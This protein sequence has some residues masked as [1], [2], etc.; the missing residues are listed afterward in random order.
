MRPTEPEQ[1]EISDQ[2]T[3]VTDAEDP[4]LR[5]GDSFSHSAR[6]ANVEIK[7]TIG[8]LSGTVKCTRNEDRMFDLLLSRIT[9]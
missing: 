9:S 4:L 5:D 7:V 3:I 1:G 6:L 2:D 8:E